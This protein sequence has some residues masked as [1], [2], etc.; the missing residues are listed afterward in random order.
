MVG[1]QHKNDILPPCPSRSLFDFLHHIVC[2]VTLEDLPLQLF[3]EITG[4]EIV[5]KSLTRSRIISDLP[6]PK[7]LTRDRR[8]V[9]PVRID[10]MDIGVLRDVC[11]LSVVVDILPHE[12]S[13]ALAY[14][15]HTRVEPAGSP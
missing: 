12:R 10:L 5:P 7:M 9:T 1:K 11:P 6:L 15:F 4:Q 8:T 2:L 3:D 13:D 14:F